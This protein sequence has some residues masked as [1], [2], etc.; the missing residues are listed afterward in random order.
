MTTYRG[1]K[2]VAYKNLTGQRRYRVYSEYH[3]YGRVTPHLEAEDYGTI[4]TA[5]AAIRA[6]F[7]RL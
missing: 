2:I 1:Y 3:D 6:H 7:G 4:E 5:K